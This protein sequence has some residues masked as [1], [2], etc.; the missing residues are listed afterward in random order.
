[1]SDYQMKRILHLWGEGLD[2]LD[3][4]WIMGMKEAV[5]YNAL[6]KAREVGK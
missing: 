6:A 1:M 4:A 3:I 5:I 2:T